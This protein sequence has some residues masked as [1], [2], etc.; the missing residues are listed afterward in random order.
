MT[1]KIQAYRPAPLLGQNRKK[2]AHVISSA[3]KAA[4]RIVVTHAELAKGKER[5]MKKK[6]RPVHPGQPLWNDSGY[7]SLFVKSN[8]ALHVV[9]QGLS[10]V[11]TLLRFS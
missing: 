8:L 2:S 9:S 1:R 11:L 6:T 10:K 7:P 4:T 3:K 5:K